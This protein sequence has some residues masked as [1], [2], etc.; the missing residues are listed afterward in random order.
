MGFEAVIFDLD[1]TL[2][3]TLAD[4]AD[5]ANS[6]LTRHGF[7]N[8]GLDAYRYFIGDGV[9][10]LMTRALPQEARTDDMIA[11]CATGFR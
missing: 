2:L 10:M 6:V 7:P 8:H 4:I 9:T 5:S 1:G 3:D 11:D